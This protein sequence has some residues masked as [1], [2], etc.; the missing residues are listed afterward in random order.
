MN[1]FRTS[2][3]KKTG[4]GDVTWNFTTVEFGS[5]LPSHI[6]RYCLLFRRRAHSAAGP[7]EDCSAPDAS[8][9][10]EVT[11]IA[12][13]RSCHSCAELNTLDTAAT[14]LRPFWS[15]EGVLLCFIN[16]DAGGI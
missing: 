16:T 2:Y 13:A 15:L 11:G 1:P 4:P 9:L 5:L 14:D 8:Q 7:G 6:G 12:A 3:L 10:D